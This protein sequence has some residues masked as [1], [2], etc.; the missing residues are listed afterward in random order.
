LSSASWTDIAAVTMN[1]ALRSETSSTRKLRVSPSTK[2]KL[3]FDTRPGSR[4]A[5]RIQ[6]TKSSPEA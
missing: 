3:C 4:G 6:L 1:P 2:S 5:N